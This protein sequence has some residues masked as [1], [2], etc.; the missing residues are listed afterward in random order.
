MTDD[1][2][3]DEQ[4]ISQLD[5]NAQ[6]LFITLLGQEVQRVTTAILL[7]KHEKTSEYA[8]YMK[9]VNDVLFNLSQSFW[10]IDMT[11]K[12]IEFAK[13]K[14]KSFKM[15]RV[16]RG[17]Y[18][19]YMLENYFFRLPKLKDITLQLLNVVYRMGHSQSPGLEKKVRKHPAVQTN[20]LFYYLDYFDESFEKIRPLRD[21][22]AHR[23]DLEDSTLAMISSYQL[24][25]YNDEVYHDQLE[26]MI[27]Y[28]YVFE[29]NQGILKQA[30]LIL[31]MHIKDDFDKVAGN[32]S[33]TP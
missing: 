25:P 16:D 13:P 2:E 18:L 28:N 14:I 21:R 26:D 12:L 31:L 30:V 10:D 8:L 17:D 4:A 22:I 33:R 3:I 29:K 11:I 6:S 20:K 24:Y 9:A 1:Q 23:G 15:T 7:D 27:A 5:W 19:K 32:L